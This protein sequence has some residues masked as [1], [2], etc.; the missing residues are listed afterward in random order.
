MSMQRFNDNLARHNLLECLIHL[1]LSCKI[2]MRDVRAI[3]RGAELQAALPSIGD[4]E[5]TL[6][7]VLVVE[8]SLS[9]PLPRDRKPCQKE[10]LH[11]KDTKTTGWNMNIWSQS[12]GMKDL[13]IVRINVRRCCGSLQTVD[14]QHEITVLQMCSHLALVKHGCI[15]TVI[16]ACSADTV[17]I[18]KNHAQPTPVFQFLQQMR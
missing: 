17:V 13:H 8:S 18:A 3:P 14:S 7:W 9:S 16:L 6:P 4:F 10:L 1:S 5:Q 12:A 2:S 15:T 11:S